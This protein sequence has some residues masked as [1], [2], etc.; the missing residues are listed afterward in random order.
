MTCTVKAIRSPHKSRMIVKY[1]I[2]AHFIFTYS[3]DLKF[4]QH[5]SSTNQL[6]N[7]FDWLLGSSRTI[8][9]LW[10]TNLSKASWL[11]MWRVPSLCHSRRPNYH[12]NISHRSYFP[13]L[14]TLKQLEGHWHHLATPKTIT[15]AKCAR[16]WRNPDLIV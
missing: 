6:S 11:Q 5:L 16:F 13:C 9:Q 3:Q 8:W 15:G 4:V 1:N 2:F 14:T 12:R 10:Q 7:I